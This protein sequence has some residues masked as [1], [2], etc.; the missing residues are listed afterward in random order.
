MKSEPDEDDEK[1]SEKDVSN[2]KTAISMIFAGAKAGKSTGKSGIKVEI[3][4]QV[5]FYKFFFK[6]CF[7]KVFTNTKQT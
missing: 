7:S 4:T 1:C 6:L 3:Q 2:K 5:Q